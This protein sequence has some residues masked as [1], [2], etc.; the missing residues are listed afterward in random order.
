MKKAMVIIG[1]LS[2]TTVGA[3][4]QYGKGYNDNN[5]A[6]GKHGHDDNFGGR[7]GNDEHWGYDRDF[8]VVRGGRAMEINSYQRQAQMRIN[9]GI[10]RGLI[11][12]MEANKL[13]RYYENIERKENRFLR[14]GRIS[15]SE[16]NELERDLA[17]LN[18]MINREK[19]DFE[20]NRYNRF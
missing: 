2:L 15:R 1:L 5:Y 19:R 17:Q 10:K 13:L 6:Y 3:F 4:A 18:R 7:R 12:R 9:E 16:A 14:N 8:N 20:R 11:T